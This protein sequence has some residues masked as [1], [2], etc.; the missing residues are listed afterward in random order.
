MTQQVIGATPM[1]VF[2]SVDR[3]VYDELMADQ[4]ATAKAGGEGELAGLLG[5]GDTWTISPLTS[6]SLPS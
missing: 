6:H 1:G 2:R 4:I 3:P 5:S